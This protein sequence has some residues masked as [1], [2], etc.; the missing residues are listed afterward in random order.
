[1]KRPIERAVIDEG[2]W[3]RVRRFEL[4]YQQN[5]DWK[6]VFAGATLGPSKELKFEPVAAQHFRLNIL[7]ANEVPTILEF[8]LWS[9]D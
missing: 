2:N 7:E 8:K 9:K 4:Q 1:M 3:D 6:T 5:D